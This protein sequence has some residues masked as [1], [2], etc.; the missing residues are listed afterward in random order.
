[1][2][3]DELEN[4]VQFKASI[5]SAENY[6]DVVEAF[7]AKGIE[8]TEDDIRQALEADSGELSEDNLEN[9]AGG[10]SGTL[11]AFLIGLKYGIKFRK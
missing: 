2:S 8:V 1:M 4:D 6:G 11:A 3:F 5:E 10:L 9:V 7:K